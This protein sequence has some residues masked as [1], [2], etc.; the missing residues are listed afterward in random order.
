VSAE[1]T[2]FAKTGGLGESVAGLARALA[3]AGHEVRVFVPMY[4]TIPASREDFVAVDFVRDVTVRSG[5]H[6]I[7]FSLLTVAAAA[8]GPQHYFVDCPGLY[9]RSSIYTGQL[10]DAGRFAFLCRATLESCQRMGW[11]P[12]VFHCNDWHTALVPL[13]LR[14][15]YAWDRLFH[16]AKTLLSVHNVGYQGTFGSE[17]L[18][19]L[20]LSGHTSWLPQL[21]LAGGSVN[22]LKTGIFLADALATVSPRHAQEIQT[23]EYGC[24]LEAVFKAR[25]GVLFGILNGV[26]DEWNP[27]T[28]PWIPVPFDAA[29]LDRKLENKRQLVG[30]FGLPFRP[31]TPVA[32]VISRLT[33]QKGVE[34]LMQVLPRFL[35]TRDFQLVA[36]GSGE[37]HYEGFFSDLQRQFPSQVVF[38][39]GHSNELAHRIE[40][41][42]DLFLM[43]SLYEP[44]GLNQMYSLRYGTVP[45]VRATG[46]LADSIRPY[47]WR[48]GEGTGFVFEHFSQ[49]GFS[50]ALDAALKT[51]E[52]PDAWRRLML[53]GMAEDFSWG[54]Q[55]ARYAELYRWLVER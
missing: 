50:W 15:H 44:C 36:L 34:L 5:P 22:F 3:R 31:G 42:A 35:S 33:R 10:D 52:H 43:P 14:T 2:P 13:Y 46:G 4:S 48:T 6:E 9:G 28:D 39:R 37:A 27:A 19:D 12:E 23:A 45:V 40:A 17:V 16:G 7:G 30:G 18:E 41:G 53:Q 38:Y 47:D 21:D 51:F 32:G 26:D 24:G 49:D 11:G 1:L 20:D 25:A 29:N 8:E 54:R 55:A